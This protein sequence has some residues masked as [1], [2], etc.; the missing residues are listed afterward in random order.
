VT[1]W[2]TVMVTGHRPQHLSVSAR[3]WVRDELR[4]LACKLRDEHG[5]RVGI[6]GMAIG[7]DLWWADAVI[8]AGLELHAH[9]PF[10]PQPIKWRDEDQAE[11]HRLLGLAANTITYGTGFDVR[12]LHARNRG[13][14]DSCDGI[15]ACWRQG[16]TG[17]TESCLRYAVQRGRR[18]VWVD[19]E[20][21]MTLWPRPESWARML[22][23]RGVRRAA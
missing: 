11:W 7:A 8:R 21:R 3:P 12:L 4:R 14:V 15:I 16:R 13:M 1:T 19:P 23:P 18:P 10:P 5:T 20:T 17:G 9:V 6:S 22:P 2:P